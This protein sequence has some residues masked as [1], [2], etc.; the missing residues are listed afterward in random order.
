MLNINLPCDPDTV[1]LVIYL[2]EVKADG[3][4]KT[5][6]Q[7]FV[8]ALFIIPQTENHLNIY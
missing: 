8:T 5:H 4:R 1:L 2:P 6:T 3:H 7:V